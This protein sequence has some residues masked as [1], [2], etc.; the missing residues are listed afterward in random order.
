LTMAGVLEWEWDLSSAVYLL[1]SS[2]SFFNRM[3]IVIYG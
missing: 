1:F 3:L 2:F